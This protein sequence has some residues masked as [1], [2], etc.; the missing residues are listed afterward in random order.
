MLDR[1]MEP[2]TIRGLV[3]VAAALGVTVSPEHVNTVLAICLG[4]AGFINILRDEA[5]PKDTANLTSAIALLT[6]RLEK[7]L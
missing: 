6:K 4:V 1:L 5:K 7:K 3:T 2:S